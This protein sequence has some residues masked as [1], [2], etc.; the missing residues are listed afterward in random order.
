MRGSSFLYCWRGLMVLSETEL[1]PRTR[2]VV[3]KGGKWF[4]SVSPVEIDRFAL[5][6][7]L[8]DTVSK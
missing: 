1:K 7:Q 5:S 4:S 6:D 8:A 3:K 2:R